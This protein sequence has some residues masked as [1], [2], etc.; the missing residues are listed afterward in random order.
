MKQN[1]SGGLIF[2]VLA[3]CISSILKVLSKM[4]ESRFKLDKRLSGDFLLNIISIAESPVDLII[5]DLMLNCMKGTSC[6]QQWGF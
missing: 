6:T 4:T 1:M 3:P 5:I 2:S